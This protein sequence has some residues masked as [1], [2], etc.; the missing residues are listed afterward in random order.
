MIE[1]LVC[2]I[3]YITIYRLPWYIILFVIYNGIYETIISE[4]EIG[5]I[6]NCVKIEGRKTSNLQGIV[7]LGQVEIWIKTDYDYACYN[8]D[9]KGIL[10]LVSNGNKVKHPS[11]DV[12]FCVFNL[13]NGLLSIC[14]SRI[15]SRKTERD[16]HFKNNGIIVLDLLV[17]DISIHVLKKD[18]L[19]KKNFRIGNVSVKNGI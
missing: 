17:L 18:Y 10:F 4:N 12:I 13:R 11:Y 19:D 1:I 5:Y 8:V 2:D 3:I 16:F 6:Q 9:N 7:F 15:I 14:H